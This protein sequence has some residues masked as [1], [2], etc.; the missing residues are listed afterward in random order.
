MGFRTERGRFLEITDHMR[1]RWRRKEHFV[2]LVSL[3]LQRI[4]VSG[5]RAAV[6]RCRGLPSSSSTVDLSRVWGRR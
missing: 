4:S 2:K 6:S 5:P 1:T 3:T